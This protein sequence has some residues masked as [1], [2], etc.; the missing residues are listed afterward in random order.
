MN[1][2]EANKTILASR[3]I[4]YHSDLAVSVQYRAF[5]RIGIELGAGQ[6]FQ[7]YG[8]K[9]KK[10]ATDTEKFAVKIKNKNRFYN[11]FLNLSYFQKLNKL[12]AVYGELGY[13]WNMIGAKTITDSTIF[14]N[15]NNSFIKDNQTIKMTSVYQPK[16]NYIH[17]EIGLQNQFSDKAMI[18]Y[19]LNFNLGQGNMMEA[20]YKVSN[21][22]GEVLSHDKFTS[23][24]TYIGF[25]IKYSG[26]LFHKDKRSRSPRHT[27][28][29]PKPITLPS[30]NTPKQVEGRNITVTHK[31]EVRSNKVVIKVWDHQKVDG[32]RISLNLNGKWIIENYSLQKKQN[33][34]EV[35]LNDGPNYF[36]LHALNLGTLP[37]NTASIIIDDGIKAHEV[38]LESTLESSGT[39][40][41]TVKH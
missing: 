26:L 25:T 6:N 5:N 13:T 17:T 40:E 12:F 24:G 21:Q 22:S 8:L 27:Q 32:D 34:L 18:S 41:I 31:I 2:Y 38:I 37:P 20:I 23:L 30:N 39:I 15:E 3:G 35:N 11:L 14:I 7:N 28:E 36:V 9:D 1:K 4:G 16:N 29:I 10:F 19:G 33:I